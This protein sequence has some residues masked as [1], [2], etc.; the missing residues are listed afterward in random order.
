MGSGPVGG[1]RFRDPRDPDQSTFDMNTP[2]FHP[3]RRTVIDELARAGIRVWKHS[4]SRLEE[5]MY[6]KSH[7]K[8]VVDELIQD[9]IVEQVAN[10][11]NVILG[12][13]LVTPGPEPRLSPLF[14]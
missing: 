3:R 4:V 1:A 9:T 14:S 6:K 7:V 8:P 2:D 10:G 13:S 11:N 5:T 12:L